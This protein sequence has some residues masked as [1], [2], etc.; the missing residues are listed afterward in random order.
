MSFWIVPRRSDGSAPCPVPTS[1]YSSSSSD[2]GALIVIDVETPSPSGMPSNSRA[3]SSTES[4]PTPVRPTSPAA[5][6]SSESSPS[7]VGRSNATDSPV[8]P[9]SSR[10]RK[11][12]FVSSADAN[13]AYW[14]IVHGRDR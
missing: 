7:C 8:C 1:S 10:S 4:M 3:M 6:G 11:R 12:S 13:P 2:A 9:R 5:R 14:R